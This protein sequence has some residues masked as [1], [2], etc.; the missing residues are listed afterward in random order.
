M[1][2]TFSRMKYRNDYYAIGDHQDELLYK[3]CTLFHV[4]SFLWY[5]LARSLARD[6]VVLPW[7]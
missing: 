3:T 2:S 7:V 1:A 4:I 6:M 5:S